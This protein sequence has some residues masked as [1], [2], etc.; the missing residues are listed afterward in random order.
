[1]WN[2]RSGDPEQEHLIFWDY[3]VFLVHKRAKTGQESVVYDLD[4]RL[5]FPCN[6]TEY[7]EEVI[8]DDVLIP[9]EYHR[10]FRVIN[11]VQYLDKF[12]SDRSRMRNQ[13]C[14]YTMTPPPY[15]CI[16]TPESSNNLNRFIRMADSSFEVGKV[17]NLCQFVHFFTTNDQRFAYRIPETAVIST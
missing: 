8:K 15:P 12:A 11:A 2:Q 17:F 16:S 13:D 10:L 4:T 7:L 6:F 5:R 14:S 3:H 9:A 1:M